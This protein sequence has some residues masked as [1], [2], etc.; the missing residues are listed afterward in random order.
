MILAAGLGKRMRPLT[1]STP[2]PLLCVGGKPLIEY[3]LEALAAA[4]VR[5]VV[6][7]VAYLGEQIK[8]ALGNGQ[9]WQ[10]AIE[11]S[12]EPSPLETAGAIAQALPLLG[13]QPFLLINAD[14]WTD[15][16]LGPL[17]SI[18]L[19]DALGHLVLVNNPEHH[20]QGDFSIAAG[21]LLERREPAYTFSGVSVLHPQLIATYPQRRACFPLVEVFREG[22]AQGQLTAQHYG[23]RWCDVG[24]VERLRG[25]DGC[26][27][28][29][30]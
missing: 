22:I 2:K 28:K 23:G 18:S 10:L 4:G 7:N 16:P 26:L 17:L 21:R 19:G 13:D 14:I 29:E 12:T 1:L 3:H 27:L 24:T 8:A 20:P 9:R 25:L 30:R 15:L 6:I 11:Y 5:E